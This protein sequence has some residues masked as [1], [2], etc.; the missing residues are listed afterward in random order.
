[1]YFCM[2]TQFEIRNKEKGGEQIILWLWL[3]LCVFNL[4]KI[5]QNI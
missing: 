3:R 2:V 4:Y 1:M 5:F